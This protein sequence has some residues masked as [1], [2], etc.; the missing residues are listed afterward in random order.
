[1]GKP[2]TEQLLK[3]T[4]KLA[5]EPLGFNLNLPD[6]L[7]GQ[8]RVIRILADMT[9]NE[10]LPHQI[11][12]QAFEELEGLARDYGKN[13]KPGSVPIEMLLWCFGVVSGKIERPKLEQGHNKTD[14]RRRDLLIDPLVDWLHK[15]GSTVGRAL[16]QVQKAIGTIEVDTVKD[17][18]KNYRRMKKKKGGI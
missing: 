7:D 11:R 9:Q 14:L 18:R 16:E 17:I 10:K 3:A 2:T 4:F 12:L 15:N 5:Q 13:G 8:A 1:M 6:D